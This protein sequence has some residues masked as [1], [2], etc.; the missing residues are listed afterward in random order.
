M[1]ESPISS[2]PSSAAPSER[3]EVLRP[4][5]RVVTAPNPGPMTFTGTR[6][7]LL[8]E[9]TLAV[10]DPGPED[11]THLAV[12]LAAI[13]TAAVS[14]IL[15]THAHRDHSAGAQRLSEAVAAPVFA[16]GTAPRPVGTGADP[17]FRPTGGLSEGAI[18]A[19]PGWTLTAIETPG[20]TPDHLAFAW[21]E[22]EALFSGDHVMGWATTVI[23]PPDGNLAAFRTSLRRLQGR[24]ET[25]FYPGH[26]KPVTAPGPL[27]ENVLAHRARRE[28]EILAALGE[29]A[30]TVAELVARIY[31]RLAP[32]LVPAAGGNVKAHLT[33]L[34]ARGQ[35][36]TD[37]E[38]FRGCD[39]DPA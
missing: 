31:P 23:A 5:L 11:E 35:V 34:V 9:E 19:G 14:A 6:T 27:I 39:A 30:R 25:V 7:Y 10:I 20:H 1:A 24:P 15:V 2:A 13:G 21:A 3:V 16:H 22:G 8:G 12:L 29:G 26:G 36:V 28:E 32:G 17:D 18:V 37:G 4:G 38:H 33:D